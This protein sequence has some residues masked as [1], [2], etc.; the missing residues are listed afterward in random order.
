MS[1]LATVIMADTVGHTTELIFILRTLEV[2]LWVH[3]NDRPTV[4]NIKGPCC[5]LQCF[6]W[7]ENGVLLKEFQSRDIQFTTGCDVKTTF[8]QLLGTS[9]KY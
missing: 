1:D 2:I 4:I 8:P 3:A 7:M 9:H 6:Y 5:K